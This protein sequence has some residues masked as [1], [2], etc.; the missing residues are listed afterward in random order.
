MNN[1]SDISK[2]VSVLLLMNKKTLRLLFV[3]YGLVLAFIL[4]IVNREI[5]PSEGFWFPL[6]GAITGTQVL[7]YFL[8]WKPFVNKRLD[9]FRKEVME[10][11]AEHS[12][13]AATSETAPSAASEASDA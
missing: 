5:N 8:A 2:L 3:A 6:I 9:P 1:E 13:A 11:I 10:K 7:G 12:H 4:F